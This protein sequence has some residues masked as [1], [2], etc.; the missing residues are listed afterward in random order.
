[1]SEPMILQPSF[2]FRFELSLPRHNGRWTK[3]GLRLPET[4]RLPPLHRL[5]KP[6]KVPE[7][8]GAKPREFFDL[9]MAWNPKGIGF[10]MHTWGKSQLPWC[11]DA[12][13]YESD[14]LHLCINTRG[15]TGIHR[16]NRFCHRF[17]FAP[18]GGGPKRDQPFAGLL[19]IDMARE[20]PNPVD[21]T[22]LKRFSRPLADGYQ[23]SGWIPAE[24]LTGFDPQE[25]PQISLSTMVLD[26]ECGMQ[27]LL[28]D[29]TF[30]VLRDPSMWASVQLIDGEK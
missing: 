5:S 12:R 8:S 28:Y 21:P 6:V 19:P 13:P 1:M 27:T 4:A 14:G 29:P 17:V 3:E 11:R 7:L 26:R 9:R 23:M 20:N 15:T 30:P 18:F 2:L 22:Q 10:A 25:F 24:L 16:S